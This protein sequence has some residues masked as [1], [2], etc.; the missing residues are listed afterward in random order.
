MRV[1]ICT[2]ETEDQSKKIL[3]TSNGIAMMQYAKDKDMSIDSIIR[4]NRED[5]RKYLSQLTKLIQKHKAGNATTLLLVESFELINPTTLNSEFISLF[6]NYLI[7]QIFLGYIKIY[8]WENRLE[9][10]NKS[11]DRQ[12][13][14]FLGKRIGMIKNE[15][16]K[17]DCAGT[18]LDYIV[19]EVNW[20]TEILPMRT[21]YMWKRFDCFEAEQSWNLYITREIEGGAETLC[22]LAQAVR[23]DVKFYEYKDIKTRSWSKVLSIFDAE[24]TMKKLYKLL[25]IKEQL[26]I[27]IVDHE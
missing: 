17:L 27:R 13:G 1:I 6:L 9:I 19:K 22:R 11:N 8:S 26:Q 10:S 14:M 16:V 12:W 18:K 23:A 20:D 7:E 3:M 24:L 25:N 15:I 2:S 5:N 21:E 4:I